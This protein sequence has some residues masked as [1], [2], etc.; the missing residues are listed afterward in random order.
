VTDREDTRRHRAI[1]PPAR[2]PL[3][4]RDHAIGRLSAEVSR[5]TLSVD[6][7]RSD[8]AALKQADDDM[9]ER[10][11]SVVAYVERTKGRDKL[12]AMFAVVIVTSVAGAAVMLI[13]HDEGLR[14]QRGDTT[15]V[16][17]RV[18]DVEAAD[19]DAARELAELNRNLSTWQ[20]AAE[21]Q[22]KQADERSRRNDEGLR[23]L[24]RGGTPALRRE[25]RERDA[26]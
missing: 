19:R 21:Q 14:E 8:V 4:D 7:V 5:C 2:T 6:A 16:R 10:M 1:P 25:L 24:E 9:H 11:D 17:A 18:A 26:Q 23:A 20:A 15:A 12:I 22:I 3:E 13:R